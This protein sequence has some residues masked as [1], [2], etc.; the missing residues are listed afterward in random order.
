MSNYYREL[1]QNNRRRGK[2]EKR[3]KGGKYLKKSK[4]RWGLII[5]VL[6]VV[7]LAAFVTY[8]SKRCSAY[9]SS[10]NHFTIEACSQSYYDVYDYHH[11]ELNFIEKLSISMFYKVTDDVNIGVV[12]TY[13][14][15]YDSRL[16]FMPDHKHTVEVVDTTPPEIFLD[17]LDEGLTYQFLD[18]YVEPG[19]YAVDACDGYMAVTT[20]TY[21]TKPCWYTIKYT[22]TDRSGNTAERFRE[23]N[24][25]RGQVALTFDDGP[26]LNI[27]PEIL[28][29]LAKN[30]VQATF[31]ILGYDYDKQYLVLRESTEGHTIGYHGMS[32]SYKD[33]YTS[34]DV[35][36]ENFTSLEN[37][38]FELTGYS[39]K[40]IRFPGGS[41]N[42]VSKNYCDGIMTKAVEE[43]KKYG[44]MYFD[45]N[46]DSE[47]AGSAT[48][49]EQVLA[50][51]ID[52]IRVGRLNVVLMHDS[53]SKSHTLGALQSI[54][55]YCIENDYELVRLDV[56]SPQ[57]THRIAN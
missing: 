53:A 40:L 49:S 36:M 12:G 50:N 46:V 57:V 37:D 25:I 3:P 32:H 20:E 1:R 8:T 31:F 54:I 52:G 44:Y 45:W 41:S 51:V 33:I 42:T 48:T 24:V 15:I 26:S 13:D 17:D 5:L 2:S 6:V 38:V 11:S 43:V 10:E 56:S 21:R 16:P 28:D 30:N 4:P 35:L 22:A 7:A 9:L 19:C 34:V 47:D 39:S 18:E 27:T 14:V 23:I 29:I 55:D